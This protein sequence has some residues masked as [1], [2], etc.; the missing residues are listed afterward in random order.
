MKGDKQHHLILV[1]SNTL[2][3]KRKFVA[4]HLKL[5]LSEKHHPIEMISPTPINE[6]KYTY[7]ICED[8]L[9]GEFLIP[10]LSLTVFVIDNFKDLKIL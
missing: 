10:K 7:A 4:E 9:M 3:S 1:E 8:L 6:V 2:E 5:K